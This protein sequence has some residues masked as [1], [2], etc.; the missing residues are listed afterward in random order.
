[1]H[2]LAA[3]CFSKRHNSGFSIL[4]KDTSACRFG[5]TWDRTADLQVGG[6]PLYPLSHSRGV[7]SNVISLLVFL[8][9]AKSSTH[10]TTRSQWDVNFTLKYIFIIYFM[11]TWWCCG[12]YCHLTDRGF[13]IW[14]PVWPVSSN[15]EFVG[16]PHVCVRLTVDSNL[17][18][19]VN[20]STPPSCPMS[21]QW[22]Q[23]PCEHN[24][25]LKG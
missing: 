7:D 14:I 3:L 4:L 8:Y 2:L 19:G 21:A 6:W 10:L 20:V 5:K 9:G 16:F 25:P 15:V 24:N 11:V 22:L 17:P 18:I 1:M 23:R 12:S 13:L